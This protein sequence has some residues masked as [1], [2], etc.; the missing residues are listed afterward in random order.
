MTF[1]VYGGGISDAIVAQINCGCCVKTFKNQEE[2]M[3]LGDSLYV[4]G[5]WQTN[6]GTY[7]DTLTKKTGC[8]SVIITQL[9]ILAQDPT[10]EELNWFIPNSFSPNDDKAN[11]ILFVRGTG[12]NSLQLIVYDRWGEKIFETT[13]I[14][15]GWDGKY[16]GKD[17]Q[18]GVYVY[19]AIIEFIDQSTIVQKGSITLL[20]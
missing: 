4:G 11:N 15:K 18:E 17:V 6:A 20:R 14:N 9:N 13:D 2:A 3:C 5:M 16:K 1:G 7:Y 12:V 8:D 10:C 19:Y